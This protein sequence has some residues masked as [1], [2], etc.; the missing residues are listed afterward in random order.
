MVALFGS[1]RTRLV[2]HT[3]LPDLDRGF[4]FQD[5][6]RDLDVS[7][8]AFFAVMRDRTAIFCSKTSNIFEAHSATLCQEVSSILT[9]PDGG[10]GALAREPAVTTS[11]NPSGPEKACL[12]RSASNYSIVLQ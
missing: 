8:W 11:S 1:L 3:S 9:H 12:C 10:L 7:L 5:M 6:D 4:F 2:D